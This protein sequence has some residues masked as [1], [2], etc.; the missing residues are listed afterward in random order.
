[1]KF[2]LQIAALLVLAVD[3]ASA[4]MLYWTSQSPIQDAGGRGMANG[5]LIMTIGATLAAGAA[6]FASYWSNSTW[7]A[8][9]ALILAVLPAIPVILPALL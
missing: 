9:V 7:L 6:L 3:V 4:V 2:L 8:L 5:F 1:M